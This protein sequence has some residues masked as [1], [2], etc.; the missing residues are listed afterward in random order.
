MNTTLGAR[1]TPTWQGKPPHMSPEDLGIWLR[2]RATLYPHAQALYFDVGV[3]SPPTPAGWV[4]PK[5][6]LGWLRLNQRRIDVVA[7]LGDSALIIEL[8]HDATPNAVGRLLAYQQLWGDD[9]PLGVPA[10]LVL[11]TDLERPDMRRL[12]FSNHIQYQVV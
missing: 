8:R 9:D 4:S 12:C 5:L 1:F 6:Q 7:D 10:E 11:I 3:G 2:W